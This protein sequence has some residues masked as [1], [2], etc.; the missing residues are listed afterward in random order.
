MFSPEFPFQTFFLPYIFFKPTV[1]AEF[2]QL[3]G[4]RGIVGG[5]FSKAFRHSLTFLIH[6]T[7]SIIKS[8]GNFEL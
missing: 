6:T 4:K 1:S 2:P 5:V 7:S 8:R 3:N